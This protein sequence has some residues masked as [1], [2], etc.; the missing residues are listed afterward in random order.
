MEVE[1]DTENKLPG[2]QSLACRLFLKGGQVCMCVGGCCLLF[3][4]WRDGSGPG[5]ILGVACFGAPLSSTEGNGPPF[6]GGGLNSKD[7]EKAR[8]RG[9]GGLC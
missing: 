3:K 1:S 2:G 7:L 4:D 5:A 9:T 6:E 8:K